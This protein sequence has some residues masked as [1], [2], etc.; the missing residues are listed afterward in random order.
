M[1]KKTIL[2]LILINL[3]LAAYFYT[4]PYSFYKAI[5]IRSV[6]EL[7]D[8]IVR[9]SINKD[10]FIISTINDLPNRNGTVF[11]HNKEKRIKL[12]KDGYGNC[13][14]QAVAMGAILNEYHKRFQ[15]VHLMPINQFLEGG[16]H[17]ILQTTYNDTLMI[18]DLLGRS[19]LKKDNHLINYLDLDSLANNS[20]NH[21][22]T[23]EIINYK[24]SRIEGFYNPDSTKNVIIGIVPD[25]DYKQF[26]TF[27]KYLYTPE[28]ESRITQA[29]FYSIAIMFNKLPHIYVQES[30][31]E[32]LNQNKKFKLDRFLSFTLVIITWIVISLL[33]ILLFKKLNFRS[34]R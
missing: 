15:V 2:T 8:L 19:I 34:K 30:D 27:T 26:Y 18:L 4:R 11:T 24:R 32:K 1:F 10:N 17:T 5:A 25:D 9:D 29:F 7:N 16:G 6:D 33:V 23:F 31:F 12:F 22:L 28:K 20:S 21:P 3:L 14:N 13:S